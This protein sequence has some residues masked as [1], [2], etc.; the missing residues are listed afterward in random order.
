M[1]TIN[2]FI[3][4]LNLTK[5][6]ISAFLVVSLVP[7]TIIIVVAINT[8][9]NSM[10]EQVYS[11]LDAVSEVKQSAVKRYFINIEKK[12]NVLQA[13]PE[14]A[15]M[16][17]KFIEGFNDISPSNS[18]ESLNRFYK[19]SF[20]P[21]FKQL[22]PTDT[23]SS[24]PLEQMNPK[25][26]EL[27]SRYLANN[28]N[29]IGEKQKLTATEQS[30]SY[31]QVHRQYHPYLRDMTNINEFY[32]IFII[33]PTNGNIVYSVYKEVDFATSLQTGPYAKSNLASLFQ[34]LKDSSN[35][36][37][38]A[39][40]DYKQYSPSYNAPASFIGKPIVVDG[41]TIAILAAQLSIEDINSIMKERDGLG[42]S[43]ETYLVGPE[44]LMRS[45]SYI[46]PINHSVESSFRNPNKGT[47]NT[48]SVIKALKNEKGQH[49]ISDYNNEMVLSAFAPVN[50]F[51]I[52]W[53]LIAEMDE[54]EAF[55][56][57][58]TL[59][60][61]LIII[62]L[63]TI[64][65]VTIAAYWFARTLTKPIHALADTMKKVEQQGDFSLRATVYSSDEIGVSTQAFNTLLDAL[66]LSIS[67]TN[68]VMNHM[69]AG[70][71]DQ[72]IEAPCRGELDTLKQATN[73]CASSL[74]GAI[75]ELNNIAIA[76]ADGQF[77]IQINAS[78]SGELGTLKSNINQSLSS[79]NNTM[80]SIVD[81]MANVEQGN[82][83]EQITYPA[84]GKLA[85]LKDS[86]NNSVNSLSI[87]I[88]GISDVMSA[89]R[90]GQFSAQLDAP[91]AG[92]LN[93]LKQDINSSMAN[94]N[95]VMNEIG[96]VMTFVSK[97]DFKKM[98]KGE[99]SGQLE[100]LK[101]NINTSITAIDNAL[102]E[103]SSV[104]LAISQGRFD[105][106]ISSTMTGQ[107]NSLKI[108][109]NQS[110]TNLEH[111]INDLNQVMAAMAN[112][113]FSH[114]LKQPLQG[115]LED[116]KNNVNESTSL[117]SLA[118]NEVSSVLSNLAKGDLTKNI[119]GQYQGVFNTLK[120]DTNA[121]I[122]K[123]TNVIQE[124]QVSASQVMQ[125]AGEIASSN[126]EISKR[127]EEQAANLEEAS[128]STEQ[129]LDELTKVSE[130]SKSA[131]AL[132]S[133]AE[134]IAEEGNQ[135]SIQTVSAIDEV[136]E[137]SKDINEILTVID[138]LAFQTNLLSLNAAVEAARAGDHGRGFAVVANEVGDL[139][140]RS[141]K[142]AKQ[143]K[144]I[145]V[146][147]NQKVALG[148]E[149]AD[150]SGKKLKHIMQAVSDVSKNIIH[151]AHS[152]SAQEQAIKEV[153]LVVQRLTGLTQANSAITEETM[154]AARQMA[155]QATEMRVQLNYFNLKKEQ[156]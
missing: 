26:I 124:I 125:N 122:D 65:I 10:T 5:K 111:V 118:I 42:E 151:I 66:Q 13:N 87:A 109:I 91:L 74:N 12:L 98:I 144:S 64:F 94:L 23:V 24:S 95:N 69:A 57:I 49:V 1:N 60:Q 92:Q 61:Q 19:E 4:S 63:I 67:E 55:E 116:L 39:F 155:E 142:S 133:N 147:S 62:L 40:A 145:I 73:D 21:K 119:E 80:N 20:T 99:A 135:L 113:D 123:L 139:A 79:I 149:L 14:M 106:T 70:K 93:T 156:Q 146:N 130:Q 46:D 7:I 105:H 101:S 108:D 96:E 43:G 68:R 103:I 89:L 117:V 77:D 141:A 30:D 22:N 112:G 3:N 11:R 71:F 37:T 153:N 127:T 17:T 138:N 115:Q 31:E 58:T 32:D 56:S 34:Q 15:N 47:V 150:T 131:V 45:D 75:N 97:G 54:Q 8:A 120:S 114:Q 2:Q 134:E 84:K 53:A 59:S 148:T 50:V 78:M 83:K 6:L 85:Q 76:M 18:S 27:Q 154:A 29:P 36:Q 152:T 41:K 126:T 72:R 128:S 51:N 107:L 88:D 129:M 100:Q 35:P 25:S 82:F 137:A 9:S 16:A 102:T 110:V 38:I 132:A 121:T 33:D 81:I 52:R 143:I 104:M 44:G 136:N 86:V 28:P 48:L 90:Q 140:G